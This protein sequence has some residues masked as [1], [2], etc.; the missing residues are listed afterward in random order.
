MI[1]SGWL[2]F[3]ERREGLAQGRYFVK[4][5]KSDSLMVTFLKRLPRVILSRSLLKKSDF[6]RKREIPTL[7]FPSVAD[8]NLID[9]MQIQSFKTYPLKLD[10]DPI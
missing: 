4:S 7:L 3:K 5:D 9:Q 6:E 8:Q 10:L 2:F 1:R